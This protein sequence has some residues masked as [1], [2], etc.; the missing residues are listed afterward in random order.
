MPRHMRLNFV[1]RLLRFLFWPI[2]A[3]AAVAIM[4]HDPVYEQ[5]HE[6]CERRVQCFAACTNSNF[7]YLNCEARTTEIEYSGDTYT[8]FFFYPYPSQEKSEAELEHYEQCKSYID[9][10]ESIPYTEQGTHRQLKIHTCF[11]QC[12]TS[13]DCYLGFNVDN[14]E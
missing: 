13:A 9:D 8:D 11:P 6:Y 3:M 7:P 1:Q 10:N 12:K 2:C 14:R 5:I 4:R